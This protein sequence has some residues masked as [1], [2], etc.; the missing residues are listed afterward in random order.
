MNRGQAAVGSAVFF[1]VA[2]AMVAG[3]VPWLITRWEVAESGHYPVP[4][5]VAGWALVVAGVP[6][7]LHAFGRFVVEGIGTPAPVAPTEKLVVGGAYRFVRNP[8]YVAVVSTIL[9][10]ALILARPSLL[11][12]AGVIALAFVTFV[13]VY[14]QPTLR[15]QFGAEYDEYRRHVPGW[16]PRLTP[17]PRTQ[18]QPPAPPQPYLGPNPRR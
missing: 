12:Y 18:Y 6:L 17:W 7:L 15:E 10:Q 2:P 14:E 8:M 5:T 4:W 13:T 16:L 9:G 11:V 3:A 1:A